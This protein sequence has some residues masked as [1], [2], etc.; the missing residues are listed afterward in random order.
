MSRLSRLLYEVP[1]IGLPGGITS[2]AGRTSS[3]SAKGPGLAACGLL[4]TVAAANS[5]ILVKGSHFYRNHRLLS[6]SC[7]VALVYIHGN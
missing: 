3:Q 2:K 7:R 1:R 5:Q 4:S 6:D